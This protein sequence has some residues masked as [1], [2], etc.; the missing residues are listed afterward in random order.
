MKYIAGIIKG[1]IDV[2][3]IKTRLVIDHSEFS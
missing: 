3:P 2:K 1:R